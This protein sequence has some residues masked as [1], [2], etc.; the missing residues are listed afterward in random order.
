M[1][2]PHVF[3]DVL[4]ELL[5]VVAPREPLLSCHGDLIVLTDEVEDQVD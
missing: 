3:P 2:A 5:V 1:A 4:V